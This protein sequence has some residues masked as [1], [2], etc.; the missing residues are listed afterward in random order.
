VP[1][2][3]RRLILKQLPR[4]STEN[5]PNFKDHR[6]KPT[7]LDN[8]RRRYRD[9]ARIRPCQ[10]IQ[11]GRSRQ[12]GCLSIAEAR[13]GGLK[14]ALETPRI[15]D[16]EAVMGE[17]E[18]NHLNRE[19][20]MT[21]NIHKLEG[22][23]EPDSIGISFMDMCQNEEP[24][25]WSKV[26]I[27]GFPELLLLFKALRSEG[28]APDQSFLLDEVEY[29]ATRFLSNSDLQEI[30]NNRS[31]LK[32][33]N[34]HTR[35]SIRTKSVESIKHKT[36]Y[37]SPQYPWRDIQNVFCGY[38]MS[39]LNEIYV[40]PLCQESLRT[41]K[42]I[43]E[44]LWSSLNAEAL[45]L[46]TRLFKLERQFG[47][48]NPAVIAAME[49][50]AALYC[51]LESYKKAKLIRRRLADVYCRALGST[52]EKTL[53][54]GLAVVESL[55]AQN[56]FVKA[57]AENDTLRPSILAV[58]GHD[59]PLTISANY[60]SGKICNYHGRDQ[61]AEKYFRQHLQIM[62]S[63]HGPKAMA[64]V[65]A[66]S[67]LGNAIVRRRPKEADILLF[68]A[69]Q[70]SMELPQVDNSPCRS[71]SYVA[72]TLLTRGAYKECYCLATKS[73]ERFSLPL[74]DQHPSIWRTRERIAWS[75]TEMGN[76]AESVKIFRSLISHAEESV[77]ELGLSDRNSE[78]G[79]AN[80]LL[81]MG[82]VEEATTWYE[83]V[84]QT[85]M[86]HCGSSND[87]TL[88]TASRLGYCYY[89]QGKYDEALNLYRKMVHML[90]ESGNGGRAI[91]VFESKILRVQDK[92]AGGHN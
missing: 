11:G 79:L 7:K 65:R 54:A 31:H 16:C 20:S 85:R 29:D 17:G 60:V 13:L 34:F 53:Q 12:G 67:S 1:R 40:F 82:E 90:H 70:L 21:E 71:L 57:Q 72:S 61:E 37:P 50:L 80:A 8:W 88:S 64:T 66:M 75:M 91:S 3:E 56:N 46:E 58:S 43:V 15:I 26:E 69:G 41:S 39:P 38:S 81:K 28:S 68:I 23:R 30:S 89:E 33:D 63:L 27:T 47:E 73:I 24:F 19:E 83:R 9:E 51:R 22:A 77:V 4:D 74:G 84:F 5:V 35:L 2:A 86:K 18:M 87:L 59:N 42:A 10:P 78:C 52:N 49:H 62:L 76:P 44:N 25:Q 14:S 48:H 6:L 36:N 92:I 32:T 45:E 55:L